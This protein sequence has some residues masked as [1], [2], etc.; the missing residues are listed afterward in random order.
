MS[1][2]RSFPVRRRSSISSWT[3]DSGREACVRDL[4][5]VVS[6]PL[7]AAAGRPRGLDGKPRAADRVE[8]RGRSVTH[9]SPALFV[10]DAENHLGNDVERNR[11][12]TV[13]K[14]DL[15]AHRPRSE[16][17]FG[18]AHHGL[19]VGPQRLTVKRRAGVAPV[20]EVLVAFHADQRVLAEDGMV[21]REAVHRRRQLK[22]R[23]AGCEDRLDV[24]GI[25]DAERV[26]GARQ[27]EQEAVSELCGACI[28]PFWANQYSAA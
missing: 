7:A 23:I 4:A 2:L 28:E 19:L 24:G 25:R 6:G 21:R 14:A 1:S 20:S 16:R 3:S 27:V 9:A 13:A 18:Q 12:G 8:P 5:F 26:D 11:T 22:D 17:L 10:S 15:L